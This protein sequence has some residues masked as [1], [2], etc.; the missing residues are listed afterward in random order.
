MRSRE[1]ALQARLRLPEPVQQGDLVFSA[2]LLC[3]E[4][5]FAYF[6][7]PQF[8]L[9][10][11]HLLDVELFGSGLRQP[12]GLEVIAELM[13]ILG[14]LGRQHDGAGAKSVTEGVELGNCFSLG[15][16]GAGR[17]LCVRVC[18]FYDDTWKN[19]VTNSE[20]PLYSSIGFRMTAPKNPIMRITPRKLGILL[21]PWFLFTAAGRRQTTSHSF[22]GPLAV[23]VK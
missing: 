15:S 1:R 3:Q 10:D 23:V 21:Y 6:H 19:P 17:L 22:C 16:F 13:E 18:L 14:F 9:R 20:P 5:Y 11:R 2:E 7:A 12:F 8:P 4:T